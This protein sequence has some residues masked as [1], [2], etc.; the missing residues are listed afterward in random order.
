MTAAPKA[1]REQAE[2]QFHSPRPP[3][4]PKTEEPNA[5]NVPENVSSKKRLRREANNAVH[6]RSNSK[7]A[8]TSIT[9]NL[10]KESFSTS[11]DQETTQ[12]PPSTLPKLEKKLSY[13]VGLI[14]KNP[15]D[16]KS[17]ALENRGAFRYECRH[18][19]FVIIGRTTTTHGNR[20]SIKT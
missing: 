1:F 12:K 10:G 19:L 3:T 8:M 20:F 14:Y 11:P 6:L 13:W 2:H 4:T 15:N 7:S 9:P 17:A 5:E 18:G 16:Q